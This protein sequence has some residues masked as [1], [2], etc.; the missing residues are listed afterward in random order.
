MDKKI[1]GLIIVISIMFMAAQCGTKEPTGTGGTFSGGTE[2]V[3]IS[4]KDTMVSEFQQSDSVPVN[5]V[6]QN[7]GEDDLNAGETKVKLFGVDLANF[8][9]SSAKTYKGTS[10]PLKGVS[11]IN[12]EGSEQEVIFGSMKYAQPVVGN[13]ISYTL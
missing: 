5:V 12:P 6:L 2:G 11:S 13:D 9:L 7:K 3:K 4:F 10:G 8:G 1:L